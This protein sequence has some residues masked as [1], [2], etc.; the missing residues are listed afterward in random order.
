MEV[1]RRL[2]RTE[3]ASSD[4][5]G[6]SALQSSTLAA[7]ALDLGLT[8]VLALASCIGRLILVH[9][10]MVYEGHGRERMHT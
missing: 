2:R 4:R 3:S 8:L 7:V 5:C 9:H 10:L 1:D 6:R